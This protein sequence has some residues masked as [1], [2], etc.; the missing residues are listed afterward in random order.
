MGI[1]C[2]RWDR[3]ANATRAKPT[4]TGNSTPVS[5]RQLS[6]C[7]IQLARLMQFPRVGVAGVEHDDLVTGE[8]LSRLG[9]EGLPAPAHPGL[10]RVVAEHQD[11]FAVDGVVVVVR[12]LPA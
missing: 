3:L 10:V 11:E 6:E 1:S 4:Q 2:I 12:A 9:H 5:G 7:P 8:L